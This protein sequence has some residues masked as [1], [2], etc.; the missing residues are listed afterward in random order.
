[1]REHLVLSTQAWFRLLR[2]IYVLTCVVTGNSLKNFFNLPQIYCKRPRHYCLTCSYIYS[3]AHIWEQ[4]WLSQYVFLWCCS[5]WSLPW[6]KKGSDRKRETERSLFWSGNCK[7][8]SLWQTENRNACEVTFKYVHVTV[9]L[10][11]VDIYV[12]VTR[13]ERVKTKSDQGAHSDI[14]RHIKTQGV[15]VWHTHTHHNVNY[16]TQDFPFGCQ[17]HKTVSA[18]SDLHTHTHTDAKTPWDLFLGEGRRV[19]LTGKGS[20]LV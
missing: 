7:N 13:F 5:K 3:K 6:T 16:N 12:N 14:S 8:I 2:E 1:M 10:Q 9:V 20:S 18:V 11:Y 15:L 17:K 4:Q 19:S